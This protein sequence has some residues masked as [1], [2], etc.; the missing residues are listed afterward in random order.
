[1]ERGYPQDEDRAAALLPD[2]VGFHPHHPCELAF[3]HKGSPSDD[4]RFRT[5]PRGKQGGGDGFVFQRRR[6]FS[7]SSG[8]LHWPVHLGDVGGGRE[9]ELEVDVAAPPFSWSPTRHY[10]LHKS[11]IPHYGS[12][13][14]PEVR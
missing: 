12:L 10:P 6:E 7:S 4:Q 14:G 5:D 13:P 9:V 3:P 8:A 1:M 2:F 11:T